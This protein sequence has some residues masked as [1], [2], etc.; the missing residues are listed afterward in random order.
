MNDRHHGK[1]AMGSPPAFTGLDASALLGRHPWGVAVDYGADPDGLIDRLVITEH[2]AVRNLLARR[3][4]RLAPTAARHMAVDLVPGAAL[5]CP[6]VEIAD[7]LLELARDWISGMGDPKRHARRIMERR[8]TGDVAYDARLLVGLTPELDVALDIF[9]ERRIVA[10]MLF[11]DRPEI[12]LG[13]ICLDEENGGGDKAE[14]VPEL[15]A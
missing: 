2:H 6:N 15:T 3:A 9:D 7:I 10:T 13:V 11:Q 4:R 14:P 8:A 12:L 5:L 1:R